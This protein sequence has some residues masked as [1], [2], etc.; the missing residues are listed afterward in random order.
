M[1]AVFQGR[2]DVVAALHRAGVRLLV[3]T[4]T[5]TPWVAPETSLH[6]VLALLYEAGLSILDVLYAATRDAGL[7][8]HRTED[9][10]TLAAGVMR[11]MVQGVR[12]R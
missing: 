1:E 6:R 2:R 7:D 11:G 8:L 3:G 9:L 5:G 12:R 10:G 4:A